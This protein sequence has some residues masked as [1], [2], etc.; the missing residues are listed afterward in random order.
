MILGHHQESHAQDSLAGPDHTAVESDAM[1]RAA[2]LYEFL[3][4][5]VAVKRL[6]PEFRPGR[7][8]SP[9]AGLPACEPC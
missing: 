9:G 8:G 3:I 7:S 5:G 1:I 4:M 2:V 6:S